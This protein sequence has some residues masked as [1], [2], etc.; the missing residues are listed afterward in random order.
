MLAAIQSSAHNLPLFVKHIENNSESTMQ[1]YLIK[2]K[3][4]LFEQSVSKLK[5]HYILP[6]SRMYRYHFSMEMSETMFSVRRTFQSIVCTLVL[7]FCCCSLK[8]TFQSTPRYQIC[9]LNNLC[10]MCELILN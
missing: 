2:S 4:N 6:R 9:L 5:L 3:L 8:S 10:T 7:F 1:I